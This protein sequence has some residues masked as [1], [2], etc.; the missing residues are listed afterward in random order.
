MEDVALWKVRQQIRDVKDLK[1]DNGGKTLLSIVVPAAKHGGDGQL[2]R[3]QKLLSENKVVFAK[4]KHVV[5]P[6]ERN[7]KKGFPPIPL[8]LQFIFQRQLDL[9]I[10]S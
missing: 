5:S 8:L 2:L 6:D 7:V 1:G 3:Y 9:F 4:S 10:K